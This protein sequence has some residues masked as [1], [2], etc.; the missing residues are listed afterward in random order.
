MAAGTQYSK[1]MNLDTIGIKTPASYN[2]D[3][4]E[5]VM[6]SQNYFLNASGILVPVSPTNPMPSIEQ[7]VE[8]KLAAIVAGTSPAFVSLGSGIKKAG[9]LSASTADQSITT[10]AFNY[11]SII[12][13]SLNTITFGVDESSLTGEKLITINSGESF[14]DYIKGTILHYS[15]TVNTS[16]FR[17]LI[18]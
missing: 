10:T 8:N 6:R 11:V 7:Y 15:S 17:Y 12:N 3:I 16:A 1:G 9:A 14:A 18:R 2:S 13:D 5:W 4:D